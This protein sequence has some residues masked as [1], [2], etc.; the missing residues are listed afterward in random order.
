MAAVGARQIINP[1]DNF[2]ERVAMSMRTPSLHVIYES[3]TTQGATAM[4]EVPHLPHGLLDSVRR[5]LVHSNLA[6]A[7]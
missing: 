3:L 6:T 5:R 2:A 4:G 7:P 1:F